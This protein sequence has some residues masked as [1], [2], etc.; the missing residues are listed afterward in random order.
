MTKIEEFSSQK[1]YVF[2]YLNSRLEKEDQ[3]YAPS[4][5][6]IL[7]VCNVLSISVEQFYDLVKLY[8]AEKKV[9]LQIGVRNA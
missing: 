9:N 4:N 5:E 7:Y 1:K 8:C 2:W 3:F 6:S